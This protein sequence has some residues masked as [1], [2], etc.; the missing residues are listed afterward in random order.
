MNIEQ[1]LSLPLAETLMIDGRA[2]HVLEAHNMAWAGL[3]GV[4]GGDPLEAWSLKVM[5]H[6][7]GDSNSVVFHAEFVRNPHFDNE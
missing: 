6:S 3:T 2:P 5:N 1:I 4:L 7:W